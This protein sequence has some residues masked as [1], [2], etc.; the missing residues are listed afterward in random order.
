MNPLRGIR[1]SLFLMAAVAVG[2][3]LWF[4]KQLFLP[5]VLAVLLTLLLTPAVDFAERFWMPRWLGSLIVVVALLA[6]A[7]AA[8]TQ[9]AAPAQQWLNPK[10]TEFR[11]LESRIR[12]LLAP[13]SDLQGA[14]ERMAGVAD[15]DGAGSRKRE[16][17][18]ERAGSLSVLRSAQPLMAG[19]VSTVVLLYF[20]LASG[21]LFLRKLIRVLPTLEDKKRAVGIARTI[22]VEI[23]RYFLTIATINVGLAVV[24]AGVLT[25][26]GMPS[27]VFWGV[28]V[29]LLN[30]VPYAGPGASLV[31]LTAGA[32]I[33]MDDWVSISAVPLSYFVLTLIEGQFLQPLLVGRRL[34]LN[35][36]VTFLSIVFWG[37]LWG[38][39]GIIVAVPILVVLKIC[40]DHVETEPMN[41]IGELV[42]Q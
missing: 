24:T 20:L 35:V 11:K 19:V 18:V 23:G 25:A 13:L 34:R 22:Q 12:E 27:A 26:L 15:G 31:L 17:V 37:W 36:V 40:A 10:S 32:L 8:A 5:I 3:A 4:G 29:G 41:A 2:A 6:G 14:Q 42:S 30:F 7:A 21:D 39:G 9:L 16:V 38:L 28:L 1:V 33:S